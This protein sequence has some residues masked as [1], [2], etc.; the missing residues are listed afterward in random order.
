MI[1]TQKIKRPQLVLVVD[2]QEINRDALEIILE[3]H[4]EVITAENGAQALD[5]M[6]ARAADL[7]L[8]MLDLMMPVMDGFA[9]LEHVRNDEVLK[10]IPSSSSPPRRAPSSPRCSW[11]RRTSSPSHST[12]RRS[13]WPVW[14]ASTN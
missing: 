7:S 1:Q 12:C 9:V 6:T 8:V 2:D 5:I 14:G 13:S 10:T 11:A 4:Y 3:D